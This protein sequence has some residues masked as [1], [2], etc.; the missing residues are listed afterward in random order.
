MMCLV[1]GLLVNEYQFFKKQSEELLELK[2]DYRNYVLAVKKVV[3]AYNK[4]KDDLHPALPGAACVLEE[5]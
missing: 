5:G 1:T 2:E 4:A 3:H